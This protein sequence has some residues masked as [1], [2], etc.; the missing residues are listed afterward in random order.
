MKPILLLFATLITIFSASAKQFP[1]KI[2]T[3][4]GTRDVIFLVP[5]GSVPFIP[6]YHSMQ[7]K[8][9]YMNNQGRKKV[10][11][12]GQCLEI[13]FS[14]NGEEVRMLSRKNTWET[15]PIFPFHRNLFL[16]VEVDGH[17]KLF[18]NYYKESVQAAGNTSSLVQ[19]DYTHF[20]YLVQ[21]GEDDLK[22]LNVLGF[23]SD[24]TNY[25]EDCPELVV[26][27]DNR[28]LRRRDAVEIVQ[29]YNLH[30]S[31]PGGSK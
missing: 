12:P 18:R 8:I 21:R 27:I 3:E 5:R 4:N 20:R 7:Y 31:H 13:S 19:D 17:M 15:G 30:C 1:G 24:M 26:R 28:E 25:F 9:R 23:R 16:K 6:D 10:L 11:R 14:N 22:L 2:I 29:F